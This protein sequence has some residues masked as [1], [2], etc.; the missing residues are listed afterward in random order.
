M[1]WAISGRG[2]ATQAFP[3]EMIHTIEAA[4]CSAN[5]TRSNGKA[6]ETDA[7]MEAIVYTRG[8]AIPA[9][10]ADNI[11][12]TTATALLIIAGKTIVIPNS[13]AE[14]ITHN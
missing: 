13:S 9:T 11:I 5:A 10:M 14:R 8:K 6:M 7:C 4:T 1:P 2:M 12:Q 3:I